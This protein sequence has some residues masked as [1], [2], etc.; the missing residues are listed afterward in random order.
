MK[1][2]NGCSLI[3]FAL[4]LAVL[5][6]FLFFA[7]GF[8]EAVST[9][10]R[11]N[12]IPFHEIKRYLHYAK[13]IGYAMVFLN[14]AGNILA[15]LPMGYFVP[16]LSRRNIG[17][18]SMSLYV[19]EASMTVEVLQLLTRVGCCDVDDVI[20]NTLG[21]MLGY[22]CYYLRKERGRT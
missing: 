9:T 22:G 5:L 8:R 18:W 3:V 15:F 6:Y 17:F 10:Y 20:L 16:K 1:K 19:M 14:L 21:G 12:F 11:Y 7:E 2:R 4:Y 13:R